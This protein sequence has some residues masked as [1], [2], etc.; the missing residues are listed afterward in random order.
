MDNVGDNVDKPREHQRVMVTVTAI[1]RSW[2]SAT[3]T[4]DVGSSDPD[5]MAPVIAAE[6]A[7]LTRKVLGG[8][9]PDEPAVDEPDA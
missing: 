2:L 9:V 3:M 7:R 6:A 8:V 4:R 1:D 5:V